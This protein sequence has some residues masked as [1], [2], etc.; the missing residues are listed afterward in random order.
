MAIQPVHSSP[1]PATLA[2]QQAQKTAQ[3]QQSQANRAATDANKT[4]QTKTVQPQSQ[5]PKPV[6]NSQGQTT[7]KILN[8]T[9]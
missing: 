8:A 4:H 9:A 6:V 5:A 7:G 2:A 1:D 3:T